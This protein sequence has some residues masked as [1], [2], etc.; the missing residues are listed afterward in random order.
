MEEIEQIKEMIAVA[1]PMNG[2]QSRAQIYVSE[3]S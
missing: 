2:I 3:N 1:K